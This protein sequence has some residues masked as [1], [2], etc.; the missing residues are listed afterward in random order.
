MYQKGPKFDIQSQF[1]MSKII[2]IF[3]IFFVIEEYQFRSTIFVKFFDNINFSMSSFSK[4]MLNFWHL[5]VTPILK[6]NN[7]LWVFWFLGNNLYSFVFTDL[8]L[9]HQYST[10]TLILF[11]ESWQ[12]RQDWNLWPIGWQDCNASS[13]PQIHMREEE[14]FIEKALS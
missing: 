7:F 4:I 8:K 13:I 6:F 9:H 10:T 11:N 2:R 5:L 14:I 3:L 1:S 12:L